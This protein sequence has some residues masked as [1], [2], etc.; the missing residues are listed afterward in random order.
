MV[1]I[2]ILNADGTDIEKY[3]GCRTVEEAQAWCEEKRGASLEWGED[4]RFFSLE[5]MTEK[6]SEHLTEE[7]EYPPVRFWICGIGEKG[8]DEELTE[9]DFREQSGPGGK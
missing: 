1:R 8:G 3:D 2:R 7:A 6:E 5:G 9:A 4:P